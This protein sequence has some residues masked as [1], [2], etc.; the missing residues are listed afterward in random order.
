MYDNNLRSECRTRFMS[1]LRQLIHL[2][3]KG[4]RKFPLPLVEPHLSKASLGKVASHLDTLRQ[5][6][7]SD[8]VEFR[9]ITIRDGALDGQKDFDTN[10][11]RRPQYQW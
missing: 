9:H 11:I 7:A 4:R 10:G 8:P 2:N 6:A 3:G 5:V 1:T